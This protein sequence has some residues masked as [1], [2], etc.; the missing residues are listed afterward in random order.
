MEFRPNIIIMEI[1]IGKELKKIVQRDKKDQKYLAKALS[2]SKQA[3]SGAYN[4]D[5]ISTDA[6]YKWCKALNYDFFKLYSDALAHEQTDVEKP[7]IDSKVDTKGKEKN[8]YSKGRESRGVSIT[9]QLTVEDLKDE[10]FMKHLQKS[11]TDLSLVD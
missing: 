8:M 6:L 11:F 1:H 7:T 2:L 5:S 4:R 3:I 9:L 10:V